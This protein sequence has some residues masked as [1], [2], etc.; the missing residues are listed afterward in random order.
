MKQCVS[1]KC[2]VTDRKTD[3]KEGTD[4]KTDGRT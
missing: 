2:N 3:K 1:D 4:R